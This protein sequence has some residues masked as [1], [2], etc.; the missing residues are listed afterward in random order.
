M[1]KIVVFGAGKYGKDFLNLIGTDKVLFLLDNDQKKRN[2]DLFGV[3]IL[4]YNEN[5][6]RIGKA[7]VVVA[8]DEKKRNDIEKQLENDG[9]FNIAYVADYSQKIIK[10]RI[11]DREDYI[12]I[13]KKSINWVK[14]HSFEGKGI[15][16]H[17]GMPKSYPEVS[18]YFIPTLLQWGYREMA[19]QYAKWLCDI[20]KEDGSW[21]DTE[22]IKPYI[23]DT[24]QILKGLLSVREFLPNV[25]SNIIRGVDWILSNA[26]DDGRLPSPRIDDFGDGKTFHEI[27]HLYCLSPIIEA[28]KIFRKKEYIYKAEKILNYY[29]ENEKEKIENFD[30]LS[31]FYA[32][33][34]EALLDLGKTEKVKMAMKKVS[35]LLDTQGIV[36]AYND[37]HWVCVPGLFQMALVWFRLGDLEHGN[38]AFLFAC[39]LQNPS[40]GWYGSY[41]IKDYPNEKNTYM[42]N[43]EISW[44]N[45]YF[46]DA[47][48]W[49]C[50]TEFEKQ[51]S[52]FF[53]T[54]NQNDERYRIIE[55]M[56]A[57]QSFTKKVCKILDVGCGKG[58][59]INNLIARLTNLECY[60]VDISEDVMKFIDNDKIIK[61]QGTITCI[62]YN[63]DIFDV[64]FACES[65]EH[66]ID[67]DS[68]VKEMARV[69]KQ[70]GMLIIID[71]NIK[72]LGE[73]QI[74]DWEQW[75]DEEELKEIISRYCREVQVHSHIE[76]GQI[77]DGLFCAWIGIK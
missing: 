23:F 34:M 28:G 51:S 53:E 13:Y 6:Q 69:T 61:K 55:K 57:K 66:A 31:H 38:K 73:L 48:Y 45:K 26:K 15:I 24:G 47:L 54:I 71:K 7:T 12:G 39:R 50:K 58:A 41:S 21:Y 70:G 27:I 65:L 77:R 74:E 75:F 63:D 18:G 60:A 29:L 11:N 43:E 52:D 62:P 5:K 4:I 20:Q 22:N 44:A 1:E 9:F 64:V 59:Y 16:C 36:P 67:I 49:K 10:E 33:V 30:L 2:K 32:Y 76:P 8:V 37:V 56:V 46:M 19:L 25:D 68:S 40:G 42:P 14:N 17:T 35:R 3:P 72:K